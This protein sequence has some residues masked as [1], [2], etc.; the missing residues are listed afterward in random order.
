MQFKAYN[1]MAILI[2]LLGSSSAIQAANNTEKWQQVRQA[3]TAA[4]VSSE[5]ADSLIEQAQK[6]KMT[7]QALSHMTKRVT[8]AHQRNLPIT[9]IVNRIQQG[10]AKG[11]PPARIG[12]ALDVLSKEL[13]WGKQLVE[14][15][16][17][18]AEVRNQPELFN[19]AIAN[20]EVARRQGF[21]SIQLEKILGDSPLNLKQMVQVTAM[22]TEWTILGADRKAVM[23]TLGKAVQS[24]AGLKELSSMHENFIQGLQQGRDVDELHQEMQEQFKEEMHENMQ[25][26]MG[27]GFGAPSGNDFNEGA[28]GG[29]GTGGG[30]W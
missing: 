14:E 9:L 16:V 3:L 4:S 29:A 27:R 10:L 8:Q 21:T 1:M 5:R 30:S 2:M 15:H 18:R 7:P 13:K 20:L 24:G 23:S 12:K 19:T 28:G 25:D 6:R 11:I 22:A 17:P 26:D